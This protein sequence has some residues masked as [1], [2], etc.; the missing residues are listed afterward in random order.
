MDESLFIRTKNYDGSCIFISK[1]AI[2]VF[3]YE[4]RIFLIEP[5]LNRTQETL[6]VHCRDTFVLKKK[7]FLIN[8]RILRYLQKF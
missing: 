7:Q 5:I 3:L 4:R 1:M 8:A 6:Y 2:V